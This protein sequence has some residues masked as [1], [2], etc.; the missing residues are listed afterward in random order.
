MKRTKKQLAIAMASCLM[1]GALAFG[2]TMAYLTDTEGATNTFTVGKVQID[3]EEPG[4]PGNTDDSVKNLVPNQEIAKDPQVE[5]TGVNDAI[6][7]MT[8]EV[9]NE[10]VTVVGADGT[11]GQ[12]ALT[13]LFWFKDSADT[14][15]TFANNW[16]AKWIELT[17]KET[18]ATT[19]AKTHKYVFAYSEKVA[20]DGKTEALFDKVQLKNVIEKEVDASTQNIVVNAYAIQAAEVLEGESA[21]LT[22]TLSAETLGKI[23][24]VY[25]KQNGDAAANTVKKDAATNNAKDLSGTAR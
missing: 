5:N 21:D 16:N 18:A 8:V 1:V 11:K 12:K 10:E 6:V 14:Q 17:G 3:L 22:D 7:F 20:K 19:D 9:P 25:F 24:D 13:D 15:G 2:G 4:Y 23:Y